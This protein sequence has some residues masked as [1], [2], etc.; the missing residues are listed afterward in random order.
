M[1][2][3]TIIT[4]S[5]ETGVHTPAGWRTVTVTAEA[6]KIS[7][8]M[9]AVKTVVALDG[10]PPHYGMSRTGA[11]RQEYNGKSIAMREVGARKRLS[12]CRVS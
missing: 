2:T 8:G 11:R 5:Y 12:A 9:A 10:E 7:A 3:N 6:E 1:D 4:I